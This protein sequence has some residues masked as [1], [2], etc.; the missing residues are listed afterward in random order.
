MITTGHQLEGVLMK[1][2]KSGL[3]GRAHKLVNRLVDSIVR[4]IIGELRR[5]NLPLRD[6]IVANPLLACG[7][8]HFSQNDEDGILLEILR[9]IEI[10]Q[11][12]AFVEFGVGD[13]TENNTIILLA[14]G[15]RGLWVGGEDLAFQVP[16]DDA[17]LVFLRRWIAKD[18]AATS[19]DEGLATLRLSLHD[20]RVAVVDLDGNDG[21]IVRAL[22]AGGLTPDVFIVEYNAKFPPSVEFEMPYNEEHR[23]QGDDYFGVSLQKWVKIFTPAGYTLVTCND[24]GANAFFVKTTHMPRFTDVPTSIEV[25]YRSGCYYR[26]P[27]TG[28]ATSPKTVCYM[29]MTRD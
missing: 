27:M 13:G 7:R 3:I 23:W 19:V 6:S 11:P 5:A 10:T 1:R 16:V 18:N 24:T 2:I 9:R 20:V 14:L 22:L 25:L 12:S 15:W 8:R 29:A 17:R 21:H 26:Y 28:H 4:P